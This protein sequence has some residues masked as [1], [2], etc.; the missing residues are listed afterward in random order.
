MEN[1]V[2]SAVNCVL[3]VHVAH[4]NESFVVLSHK[5]YLMNRCVRSKTNFSALVVSISGS[6]A[7]VVFR[8]SQVIETFLDF[9]KGVKI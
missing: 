8:D 1:W 2:V 9:D 6:S 4:T 7:H 3:S 5:W